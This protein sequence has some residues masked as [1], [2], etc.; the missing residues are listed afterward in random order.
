[1]QVVAAYPCRDFTLPD[2]QIIGSQGAWA[3]CAEC[4]Q[5][6]DTDQREALAR[7]AWQQYIERFPQ[8]D[9]GLWALEGLRAIQALFFTH[10][11]GEPVPVGLN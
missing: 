9:D 8:P 2:C 10:R 7:R 6:I 3:A 1:M 11:Y 5:L 4:A